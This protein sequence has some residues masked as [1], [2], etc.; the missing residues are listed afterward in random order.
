MYT[1]LSIGRGE[2]FWGKQ[3][4][5][6]PKL[7]EEAGIVPESFLVSEFTTEEFDRVVET[8]PEQDIDAVLVH[9]VNAAR[10]IVDMGLYEDASL[11]D[12]KAR[13]PAFT[14]GVKPT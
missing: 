9:K 2:S 7:F 12:L 10:E 1:L 3:Y 13:I 4:F 6:S 11:S 5:D 14:P 8:Y